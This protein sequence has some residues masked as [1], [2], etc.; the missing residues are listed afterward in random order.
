MCVCEGEESRGG[1]S[2]WRRGGRE[3]GR[4]R[5]ENYC[6]LA[7]ADYRVSISFIKNVT[8]I[9]DCCQLQRERDRDRD[10]DRERERQ[11]ERERE[12]DI[13]SQG[14]YNQIINPPVHKR[15]N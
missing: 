4:G 9:Q 6:I 2:K 12:T 1:G 13:N 5:E 3:G 15:N 14:R 7:R 8:L 10:R 11:K